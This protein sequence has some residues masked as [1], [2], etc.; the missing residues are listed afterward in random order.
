M[1]KGRVVAG[2]LACVVA[3]VGA[4]AVAAPAPATP[5][6]WVI[7]SVIQ[8]PPYDERWLQ[9]ICE[10]RG[11][12]LVHSTGPAS[13]SAARRSPAAAAVEAPL[14]SCAASPAPARRGRRGRGGW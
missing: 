6:P 9:L 10:D 12:T 1:R 7:H 14:S 5:G 3:V 4:L 8:G 2:L 11:R 13:S